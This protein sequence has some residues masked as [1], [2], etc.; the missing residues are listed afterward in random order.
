MYIWRDGKPRL[1]GS[2]MFRIHVQGT[3]PAGVTMLVEGRLVADFAEEAKESGVRQNLP[4]DLV[5]DLSDVTF[6]DSTGEEALS[7]LSGAGAKFV[8]ESSYSLYRCECLQL[9]MS[10]VPVE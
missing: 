1:R 9:K 5:V 2:R 3:P 7:W 6:A 4:A 8:A 10:P